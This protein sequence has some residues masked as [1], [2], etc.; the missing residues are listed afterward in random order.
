MPK[1][2]GEALPLLES[3]LALEP[4][5]A[6]VHG[7]LAWCHQTLFTRGGFGE[8]NGAAA[9]RHARAALSHGRDDATALAL[10]AFALAMVEHDRATAFKAFEQAVEL[11]PSPPSHV[12][13]LY[14]GGNQKTSRTSAT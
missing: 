13:A 12:Y 8:E 3:A 14:S 9:I 7:F 11:S 2:A 6:G 5:Y 1:E 4:D 10:G